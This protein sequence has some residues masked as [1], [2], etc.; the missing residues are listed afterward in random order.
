MKQFI[1]NEE[2][3]KDILILI[4]NSSHPVPYHKVNAIVDTL[5]KLELV[6]QEEKK[7]EV[8]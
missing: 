3:V 5:N 4:Y 6:K 2:V 8:V 1:I 7:D